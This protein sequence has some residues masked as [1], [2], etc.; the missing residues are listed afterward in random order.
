LSYYYYY[1]YYSYSYYYYY[2]VVS[3]FPPVHSCVRVL[4]QA[5]ARRK[6]QQ[7]QAMDGTGTALWA[8][9]PQLDW[10]MSEAS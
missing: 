1:Y 7:Q 4:Q 10:D 5:D 8:S 6:A 3:G 2:M 9:D